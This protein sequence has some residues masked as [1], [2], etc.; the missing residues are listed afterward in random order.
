M[1]TL[2]V[3]GGICF[4]LNPTKPTKK[5]GG[6]MSAFGALLGI[7]LVRFGIV[8]ASCT[9]LQ[10]VLML[11]LISWGT[12]D[13]VANGIAFG[14]SA[15]VNFLLSAVFT[16]RDRDIDWSLRMIY[17]HW[18]P[19]NS[20]ALCALVANEFAF[21]ICRQ[22]SLGYVL[23]SLVG[24]CAGACVSFTVNNKATFV[25]TKEQVMTDMQTAA[26]TTL[27]PAVVNRLRQEGISFFMPAHNEAAN[28]V[29]VVPDVVEYFT[30][31][32]CEFTV[33]VVNDGSS[34][35]TVEVVEQLS[36]Q[37]PNR[38]MMAQHDV[39]QGYGAGLRTGI[40]T[41]LSATTHGLVAFFDADGQFYIRDIELLL[42]RLILE[43]AD[44]SI[45]IRTDRADPILRRLMGRGWHHLSQRILNY[46]AK[47]VDC[48]F[49]VFSRLMLEKIAPQLR[50]NHAVISP[51]LLIRAQKAG[52]HMSEVTVRHRA[53]EAGEQS[54]AN[55]KVVAKSLMQLFEL[56]RTIR[57]E[58]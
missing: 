20:I 57:Q 28:L 29:N 39:N 12:N 47:D 36:Q 33:I 18:L 53:R 3:A 5:G 25:S 16:F 58:G 43:D 15:Q 54:G 46:K 30:L 1:R 9:L 13:L 21:A 48:G 50:G 22:L 11:T 55:L 10:Q 14:I 40:S 32:G 7:R 34:D 41:A 24:A 19:F 38:V 31:I 37:Y 45:G 35:N 26:T 44:L 6:D 52:F 2:M 56:R 4:L 27:N 23:A 8:A 49:K 51:E 42:S 17:R